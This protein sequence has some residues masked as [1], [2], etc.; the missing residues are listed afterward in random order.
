[1]TPF[2]QWKQAITRRHFFTE[3][4]HILGT[5][6]LASLMGSRANAVSSVGHA[7]A[8]PRHFPGKAKHVIYLHM[9]GGPPQI[10]MYDYKP[11]MHQWYDKDLPDSVRMG[12]RLTT[13]TSGQARFPIAPS[14][15]KF[16]QCGQSRMWVSELLPWTK[17][18]VDDM[19][20]VRSMH[21]EAINHEPAIS[22]MQTGNQVTGR[23]CLGAWVSYGL[24]S[25]NQN[26][27]TFVVMVAR[28]TNTEQVQ[29]IS[30]RLWSSGYL[31]GEH[32]ATPFRA[33][34]DAILYINNPAGVPRGVRRTTLDGLREL[35]EL[36]HQRLGDPETETRIQQYE[37]AF[38]MQSS[39]PELTDLST[40]P[41]STF[42]LYGDDAKKP[43]TFAQTVLLARRMVERGVRFVQIYH[44]N[45]DTHSNVA[46]RLPDQC[47][48]V[49]QACYG[50]IQD[51]KRRGMLDDTLVIWGGEF[52][53]TVYSQGGLSKENYGRDHHPRCFTMWMAGG[54]TKGGTIHGETD[55]FSYNI[56]QDPVHVRD[57]HATVMHLLGYHHERFSYKYQGLDQ[58]LTGVLPSRVV[59]EI[60]A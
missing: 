31:S 14:K 40:E 59:R 11:L 10:D 22:F 8:V 32:A 26:L 24:G 27:P 46:G 25:L 9:V 41:E 53:R 7:G 30:A 49:D 12:Q 51:L 20:F 38:R 13:M 35:N 36:T 1:M 15:Y 4:S 18:M 50:L 28:P 19:V 2:D 55:A 47:R 54:G 48:D 17:K 16:E 42:T 56:V 43:G 23:P 45:W 58:R 6:A 3:G 52:G 39:V 57:F 29:A 5:A 44:N 60:L 37:L 21:T 33:S 34:R